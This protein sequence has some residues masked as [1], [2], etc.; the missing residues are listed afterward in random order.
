MDQHRADSLNSPTKKRSVKQNEEKEVEPTVTQNDSSVNKETSWISLFAQARKVALESEAL[1]EDFLPPSARQDEEEKVAD[2][3]AHISMVSSV[4][5]P[6]KIDEIKQVSFHS[7]LHKK[8]KKRKK[9][10]DEDEDDG[11]EGA[12]C[13]PRKLAQYI[14]SLTDK[15]Q[16][17]IKIAIEEERP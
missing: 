6:E 7:V 5:I 4:T 16:K 14:I 12:F 9:N 8:K 15:Q 17:K 2:T 13:Q 11:P 3:D 10:D 1:V